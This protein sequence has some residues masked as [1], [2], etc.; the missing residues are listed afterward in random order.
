MLVVKPVP[1]CVGIEDPVWLAV[2]PGLEPDGG[3]T[4][5]APSVTC[6]PTKALFTLT[7]KTTEVVPGTLIGALVG[8][9]VTAPVGVTVGVMVTAFENPA[10]GV[11]ATVNGDKTPWVSPV[12]EVRETV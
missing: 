12:G 2:K 5:V 11:S 3:A 6:D 8:V 4:A 1:A 9:K 10:A 7:E